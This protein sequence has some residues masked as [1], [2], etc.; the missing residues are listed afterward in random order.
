MASIVIYDLKSLQTLLAMIALTLE[1]I[2]LDVKVFD[3]C[4]LRLPVDLRSFKLLALEMMGKKLLKMDDDS[5]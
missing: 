1:H 3:I 5:I 4:H 2:D